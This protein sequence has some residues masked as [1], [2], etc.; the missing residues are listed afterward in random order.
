MTRWVVRTIKD[1]RVRIDGKIYAPSERH[2]K[3][4]GRLDGMRYVFARYMTNYGEGPE[5]EPFVYM[6]GTEESYRD[7]S[8][9]RGPEVMEDGS[10]PWAWWYAATELCRGCGGSGEVTVT[11]MAPDPNDPE[12]GF[13]PTP[14][15]IPCPDCR[16]SGLRPKGADDAP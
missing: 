10:M 1:G 11:E 14:T 8:C 6:W 15:P 9:P 2:K 16:G 12:G 7:P 5:Y 13:V 4:D 3:Y